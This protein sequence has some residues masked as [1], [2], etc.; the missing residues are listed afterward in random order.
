MTGTTEKKEPPTNDAEWAR[1]QQQRLDLLENPDALRCG[2]WVLSTQE[3]TGDLIASHVDGGS[4]KLATKPEQ[5]SDP[6]EVVE[7]GMTFLK[8][9]RNINQSA[10]SN[11]TTTIQWNAVVYQS[12]AWNIDT[13]LTEIIVP[14]DGIYLVL[15]RLMWESNNQQITKA[16]L[17]VDGSPKMTQEFNPETGNLW[18][19]SECIS[20]TLPLNSG[21]VITCGAYPSGVTRN[22]GPSGP[23]RE[24]VTSLS[25]VKLP[26][27]E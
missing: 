20:D 27:G 23:D 16:I 19:Q 15:F 10:P 26:V 21:Q 18:Y 4:V 13:P 11:V 25:L 9:V 17:S 6:D 12:A 14:E 1:D 22:F 7:P 3:G 2:A 8:L 5:G 24:S